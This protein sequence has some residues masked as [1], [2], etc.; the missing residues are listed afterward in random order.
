[1]KEYKSIHA[2]FCLFPF[3]FVRYFTLDLI[4]NKKKHQGNLLEMLKMQA[5]VRT[6]TK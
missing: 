4:A 2:L 3:C 5:I 1:M 6:K